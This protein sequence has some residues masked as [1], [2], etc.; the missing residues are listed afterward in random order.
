M[1]WGGVGWRIHMC[2]AM[3]ASPATQAACKGRSAITKYHRNTAPFEASGSATLKNT[4]KRKQQVESY[5][6]YN[7]QTRFV[8]L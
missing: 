6:M 2:G 8:Q 7:I 5:M 4:H 3:A 1:R